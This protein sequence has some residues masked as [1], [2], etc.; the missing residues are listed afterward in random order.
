MRQETDFGRDGA[1]LPDGY[2]IRLG[3]DDIAEDM[4]V[5]AYRHSFLSEGIDD[6][7]IATAQEFA[8]HYRFKVLD[9]IHI[10]CYLSSRFLFCF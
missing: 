10:R 6:V 9:F 8:E 5:F 3:S 7:S 2:Q 4:C 1:I